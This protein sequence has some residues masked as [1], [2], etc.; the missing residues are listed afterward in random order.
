MNIQL[1]LD[2][3]IIIYSGFD[4]IK[5][6][7]WILTHLV[8]TRVLNHIEWNP[9][10]CFPNTSHLQ[11]GSA[12]HAHITRGQAEETGFKCL[13]YIHKMAVTSVQG[14]IKSKSHCDWQSVSLSRSVSPGFVRFGRSWGSWPD[15]TSCLKVSALSMWG[16]PSDEKTGLSF[17][18][19]KCQ[20]VN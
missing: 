15:I 6:Y 17:V 14:L 12:P 18:R 11:I 4:R 19:V 1:K 8:Y 7:N 13:K 16:A 3:K 2:E 5:F 10:F 9:A 20:Y